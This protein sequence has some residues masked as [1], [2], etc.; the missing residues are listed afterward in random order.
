MAVG[1]GRKSP[2][3]D[4]HAGDSRE[5]FVYDPSSTKGFSCQAR[6]LVQARKGYTCCECRAEIQKDDGHELFSFNFKGRWYRFRTCLACAAV[7]QDYFVAHG[8]VWAFTNLWNDMIE[9]LCRPGDPTDWLE[10]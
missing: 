6:S 2:V 5:A 7:R 10:P 8:R 9:L 3:Y 1:V 4:S